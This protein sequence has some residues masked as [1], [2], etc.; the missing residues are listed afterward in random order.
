MLFI[1]IYKGFFTKLC[2]FPT[3][4]IAQDALHREKQVDEKI[5][6]ADLVT[7]T[8]IKVEKMIFSE[9]RQKFPTHK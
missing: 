8:D 7:E 2:F 6:T 9:L 5:S 1:F 3:F 4:Q